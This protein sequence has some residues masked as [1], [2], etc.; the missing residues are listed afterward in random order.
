MSN[1]SHSTCIYC[2]AVNPFQS[3]SYPGRVFIEPET[4][5]PPQERIFDVGNT[6]EF[7]WCCAADGELKS[8]PS[9]ESS[10][11]ELRVYDLGDSIVQEWEHLAPGP[12]MQPDSLPTAISP[13][14]TMIVEESSVSAGMDIVAPH[15]QSSEEQYH[16]E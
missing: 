15:T 9:N 11:V 3:P 14:D 2:G 12:E 1:T 5:E 16:A 8:P 10:Q 7:E 6:T 4:D 13:S